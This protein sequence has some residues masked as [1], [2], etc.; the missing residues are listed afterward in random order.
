ASV[1]GEGVMRS[2]TRSGIQAI[3]GPQRGGDGAPP[4]AEF[5]VAGSLARQGDGVLARLQVVDPHS[6]LVLWTTED[7]RATR[8][9]AGFEE[10]LGLHAASVI[11]CMLE[12]REAYPAVLD[13]AEMTNYLNACEAL[14]L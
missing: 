14:V 10:S 3:P 8:E 4:P 11:Q 6:G 13:P 9:L 7:R 12:D 2:F 5:R 1:M